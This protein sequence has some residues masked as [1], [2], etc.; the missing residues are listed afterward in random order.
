MSTARSRLDAFAVALARG[1]LRWRFLVIATA[2]VATALVAMNA[3]NLGISNNYRVFFSKEN[4]E[5]TAFETFQATYTKN[6][7]FLFVVRPVS[8]GAFDGETLEAVEALTAEAWKIPFSIRVD[9][10]TNFQSTRGVDDDLIVEDLVRDGASLPPEARAEKQAIAL[11]EPILRDQ[12]L[13][14]DA[15]VTAV[16]VVLQYPERDLT[17]VPAA[18]AAARDL[19]DRIK[20]EYP[21]IDVKLTGV[22]MLNNAFAES[23][24]TDMMTLVPLMYLVV[25]IAAVVALRSLSGT[26]GTLLVITT[27]VLVAMGAAGLMRIDL[28]PIS[29][30]APTVIMTLAVADSIHILI[31]MRS[32]MRR[33]MAKLDALVEAIRVNFLAVSITSLTTI[34]G[35]LALNFSDAP[36]FWHLGNITAVGIA[37]A[38]V[39]SLTLLPAVIS[40]L[41]M[42]VAVREGA[43]TRS[44]MLRLADWVIARHKILL[45]GMVTASVALIAMI[46]TITFNDQ[47]I[48]YFDER[49]EFRTESDVALQDF[50]LYPVEFSVPAGE[51]G[52]VSEPAFLE[53]LEGFTEWLRT[54]PEVVHVYSLA[55]IMQRLN[56]NMHGDDES[57]FRLPDDRELSAQYLL[58]YELSLPFGLDLNDRV[59]IDKSATRV[60]ATLGDVTT[61]QTK[62][63]LDASAAYIEAN[64]PEGQRAK[65]TSAQVMFTYI[66]DR[67]VQ[68][69]IGG[70]TIAILAISAIMVV[71]L[72]SV[73][74]GI[75]SLV[76][77]ALPILTTF[78][79]WALLVEQVGFSVATVASISL[80][81]IVDD[82]VHF[83][84]K[85]QR[86]R[87]ENGYGPED[88]IRYAF[89][90]VGVALIVNTVILA[91]GFLVLTYSSFKMNVD[92]GLMTVIAIIFAL[93]LDFL[94]LPAL[95]LIGRRQPV[96]ADAAQSA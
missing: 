1:V 35:F 89:D 64:F 33:G 43:D 82:T 28:T 38:W 92:L 47:W 24:M 25:L 57:Y 16:N 73:S 49:I 58:L 87:R 69:M 88:A 7:N 86:A 27:S 20:A 18:A 11:A 53:R 12:L 48:R 42:K 55:D 40:L 68:N 32:A 15:S 37:A 70:T 34:V 85:Y 65:P 83:L 50:G 60:T 56:K 79:L 63:F 30:S 67:N 26:F 93:I 52:G 51:A 72:R 36:P 17:E 45:V 94:L 59:N 71:A 4:P 2:L 96:A 76:P 23:G 90:T 54:R 31:S 29:F 8:E 62:A 21:G 9:S 81:I 13:T 19:R 14:R 80:G 95:L 41:P 39:F 44:A 22:S 46:P 84:T 10:I 3:A 78:G 5:L 6:D 61:K 91:L 74:L 66:T 77:N 75:L